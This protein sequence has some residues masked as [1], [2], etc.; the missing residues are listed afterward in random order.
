MLFSL[1]PKI[2]NEYLPS[3]AVFTLRNLFELPTGTSEPRLCWDFFSRSGAIRTIISFPVSRPF[4]HFRGRESE[5]SGQ[6][7]IQDPYF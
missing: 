2:S 1:L 6:K 3:G 5:G 4:F 7:I